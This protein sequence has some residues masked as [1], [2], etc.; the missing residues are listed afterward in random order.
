MKFNFSPPKAI[1]TNTNDNTINEN[2]DNNDKIGSSNNSDPIINNFGFESYSKVNPFAAAM[3]AIANKTNPFAI[4][5]ANAS[6]NNNS[7][8]LLKSDSQSI[9]KSDDKK[10]PFLT[11]LTIPSPKSPKINP[12]A[13]TSP[14]SNPFMKIVESKEKLWDSVANEASKP[15]TTT[16][17]TSTD[18]SS[19]IENNEKFAANDDDEGENPEEDL[20]KPNTIY[21]TYEMPENVVTETGEEHEKCKLQ[22]RAKLYRL[23]VKDSKDAVES[24]KK[25][26]EWLEVG[27]GP[28]KILET[29]ED[30]ERQ[31]TSRVVMRREGEKK[32]GQGTKLLLN[33]L[34][35]S[36]S[37]V[38]KAG[39]KMFRLACIN[40]ALD[41]TNSNTTTLNTYLIKTKFTQEADDLYE[42]MKSIIDRTKPSS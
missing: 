20:T 39:D 13:S 25:S 33:A 7:S 40:A 18:T 6:G 26:G 23:D 11:E 16:T 28:I 41:Q 34:L 10:P 29:L 1:D 9:P 19:T 5:I 38:T 31:R 36:Y 30:D 15:A 32:G 4:A 12:F 24:S 2:N 35:K 14:S 17:E 37:S 8:S 27:V 21:K 42:L 3:S 22:L